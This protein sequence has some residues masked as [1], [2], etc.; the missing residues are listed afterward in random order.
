MNQ[1]EFN[2][3]VINTKKPV[4]IDLWAPWCMPCRAMEPR[5]KVVQKKYTGQVEVLKINT[6]ESPEVAK[7]LRVMGIPTVIGFSNGKEILRRTGV[8]SEQAL[9]LIFD[10]ALHQRKPAI[11]PPA[12]VDRI[13][14]TFVGI[15]VAIVG[16]FVVHSLWFFGLGAVVIFTAFYDRCPIFK[17]V[18]PQILSFFQKR[19]K[20]PA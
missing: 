10:A 2:R 17:M 15:A 6:D 16:W 3:R 1:T 9:D 20:R 14:R 19:R 12:P 5:F 13:I 7:S 8:Q 4:V 18:Y 11:I